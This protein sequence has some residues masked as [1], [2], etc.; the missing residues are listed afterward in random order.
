MSVLLR[1]TDRIETLLFL[2]WL[3]KQ[4]KFWKIHQRTPLLESE[5]TE[6]RIHLRLC[7]IYGPPMTIVLLLKHVRRWGLPCTMSAIYCLLRSLICKDFFLS[8]F[9]AS[10]TCTCSGLSYV[11]VSPEF[12]GYLETD[13]ITTYGR[14]YTPVWPSW[15]SPSATRIVDSYGFVHHL[16]LFHYSFVLGVFPCLLNEFHFVFLRFVVVF[17]C[18]FVF[19]R[20]FPFIYLSCFT[21]WHFHHALNEN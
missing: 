12:L 6:S 2:Y 19:V 1:V 14:G 16:F 15:T 13:P 17:S 4:F 3:C 20:L 11:C 9:S 21:I 5:W 8:S 7:D 10:F 18:T